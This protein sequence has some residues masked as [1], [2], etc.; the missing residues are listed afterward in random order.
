MALDHGG[1]YIPSI[2]D[3]SRKSRRKRGHNAEV[4]RRAADIGRVRRD[5]ATPAELRAAYLAWQVTVQEWRDTHGAPRTAEFLDDP[6]AMP[7]Q[8]WDPATDPP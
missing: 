6:V 5:Y 1:Q 8:A 2:A 4:S 7:D 3:E